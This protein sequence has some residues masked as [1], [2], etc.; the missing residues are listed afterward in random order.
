MGNCTDGELSWWGIV[1]M[2][3]CP[4]GELSLVWIYHDGELY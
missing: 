2:G 1:L 3:N 4:D